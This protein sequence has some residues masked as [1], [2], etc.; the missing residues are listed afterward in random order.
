MSFLDVKD[1][2]GSLLRYVKKFSTDQHRFH[3][4]PLTTKQLLELKKVGLRT[5]C[6]MGKDLWALALYVVDLRKV[7]V[8]WGSRI[9]KILEVIR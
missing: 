6:T 7:P 5:F 1:P 4:M 9:G 8:C 2:A 3:C